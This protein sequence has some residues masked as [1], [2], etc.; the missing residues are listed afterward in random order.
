MGPLS[1]TVLTRTSTKKNYK[2]NY[3]LNREGSEFVCLSR[4][5]IFNQR[6]SENYSWLEYPLYAC[7]SG[8]N[9]FH[10]S[11]IA[12]IYLSLVQILVLLSKCLLLLGYRE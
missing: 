6:E 8:T 2:I 10:N 5:P 9:K 11:Q 1:A 7:R 12:E 4:F 3:Q